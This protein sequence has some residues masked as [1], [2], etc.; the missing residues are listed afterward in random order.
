MYSPLSHLSFG[1]VEDGTAEA[2]VVE[3]EVRDHVG[4]GEDVGLALF[5]GGL[6]VWIRS[7]G[8]G[9]PPP[10]RPRKLIMASGR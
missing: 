5:G 7:V 6:L 8:A 9:M 2:D 3:V 10:M 1:E 4:E